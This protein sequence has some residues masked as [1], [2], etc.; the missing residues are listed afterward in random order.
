MR[1]NGRIGKVE[2]GDDRV[3][4]RVTDDREDYQICSKDRQALKD[5][6]FLREGQHI[7]I[8]GEPECDMILVREAR[9]DITRIKEKK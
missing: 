2:I 1:I 9:I 3:L 7:R 5:A 6:L 8:E 4:Y